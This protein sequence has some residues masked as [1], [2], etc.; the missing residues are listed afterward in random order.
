MFLCLL[1]GL[2]LE[3]FA[4]TASEAP[5][6]GVGRDLDVFGVVLTT[7]ILSFFG[8]ALIFGLV[9]PFLNFRSG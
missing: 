6:D 4:T 7:V 8:E 2:L 1:L 9:L 3:V 5:N